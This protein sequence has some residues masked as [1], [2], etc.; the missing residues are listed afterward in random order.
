VQDKPALS[1]DDPIIL[2]FSQQYYL[3]I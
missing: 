3:V 1:R 2:L